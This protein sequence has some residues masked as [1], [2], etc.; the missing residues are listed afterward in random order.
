MYMYSLPFPLHVLFV[1]LF[2]E[3]L[4]HRIWW[5]THSLFCIGAFPS[6]L[7]NKKP[8]KGR[9]SS[10]KLRIANELIHK[11]NQFKAIECVLKEFQ[12]R[13]TLLSKGYKS[14]TSPHSISIVYIFH[15]A[16]TI[17]FQFKWLHCDRRNFEY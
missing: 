7:M 3:I 15:F 16:M 5:L 2:P 6:F 10:A 17:S 9:I 1:C 11:L 8:K 4:P 13:L 12:I 14:L